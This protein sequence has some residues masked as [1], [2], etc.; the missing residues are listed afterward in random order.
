M[1]SQ[2]IQPIETVWRGYRFRS[3]LEARWAVFFSALGLNWEYEPE[4]FELGGGLRYLPDFRVRY[5]GRGPDEIHH[6]WFEVKGDPTKLTTA[7]WDK[8]IAFDNAEGLILLDGAPDVRMYLTPLAWFT[9]NWLHSDWQLEKSY[10]I[11]DEAKAV[12]RDGWALWSGK[13]RIWWD[14]HDVFF[15]PSTYFGWNTSI[16]DAVEASRAARFE[17]G[18]APA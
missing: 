1:A 8:L 2:I 15:S 9:K 6:N 11:L 13:G 10:K 7:E 3:R 4:G 14:P 18:Q 5:P 16:E 12:K 17:F